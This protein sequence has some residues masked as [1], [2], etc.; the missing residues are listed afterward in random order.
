MKAQIRELE[1][2]ITLQAGTTSALEERNQLLECMLTD[3]EECF[4]V[5]RQTMREGKPGL[6]NQGNTEAE[7]E[8]DLTRK[9]IKR[10]R[11]M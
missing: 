1:R 7:D 10:V 6:K 3:F 11:L 9:N 4:S 8:D 2:K 5:L